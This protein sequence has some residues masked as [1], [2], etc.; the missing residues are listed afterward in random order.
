MNTN[1]KAE[2]A[3]GAKTA[4]TTE[5]AIQAINPL[6]KRLESFA[7][8]ERMVKQRK[9]LQIHF[10]QLEELEV[11][12]PLNE[13]EEGDRQSVES[14]TLD[15]GSKEYEI[16]NATLIEKVR[17]FLKDTLKTRMATLEAEIMEAS[18]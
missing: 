11:T 12:K 6:Q 9:H 5:T 17:V 7:T 13:F 8:I 3:Q 15:L 14:I 18:I 16:K 1:K 10:D 4:Q 2:T